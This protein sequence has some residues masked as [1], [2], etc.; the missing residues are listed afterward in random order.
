MVSA[1]EVTFSSSLGL[2][3]LYRERLKHWVRVSFISHLYS[4]RNELRL[5]YSA[6]I[7]QLSRR[8]T[9]SRRRGGQHQNGKQWRCRD[10]AI[11]SWL[12][13]YLFDLLKL[14]LINVVCRNQVRFS[15]GTLR[16]ILKQLWSYI[17]IDILCFRY[18]YTL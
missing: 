7:E 12:P 11:S 18:Y 3:Y 14:T 1:C 13:P 2:A 16:P 15:I 6:R 8:N 17:L 9:G 5:Q 10:G 4:S